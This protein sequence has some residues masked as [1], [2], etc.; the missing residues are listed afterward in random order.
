MFFL[1]AHIP[2]ECS[3]YIIFK[4]KEVFRINLQRHLY[5]NHT[6]ERENLFVDVA[7]LE[8]GH[9]IYTVQTD[10]VRYRCPPKKFHLETYNMI[11]EQ[12]FYKYSALSRSR[13]MKDI[14]KTQDTSG[15]DVF[16]TFWDTL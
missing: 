6:K 1:T 11:F 14:P 10:Q 15:P 12:M 7:V 16:S 9:Y 8:W 13:H 2:P 5:F 4:K 3:S